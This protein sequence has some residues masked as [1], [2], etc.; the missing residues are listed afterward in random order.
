MGWGCVQN[1]DPPLGINMI[2]HTVFKFK[3]IMYRDNIG[4]KYA[5]ITG[6]RTV[7]IVEVVNFAFFNSKG[8]F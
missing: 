7:C 8:G 4:K 5:R 3:K 1:L 6:V 2:L